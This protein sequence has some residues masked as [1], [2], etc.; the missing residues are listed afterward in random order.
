MVQCHMKIA[1]DLCKCVP[2]FYQII[3]IYFTSYSY[4]DA[5]IFTDIIKLM[6]WAANLRNSG[7]TYGRH[8]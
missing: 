1:R 5:C 7:M 3:G 6:I 8:T 4:Q 2:F